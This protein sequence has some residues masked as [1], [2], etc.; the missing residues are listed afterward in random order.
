M[1]ILIDECLPRKLKHELPSHEVYTVPEIGWA[2]K[3]NGE[4]LRLMLGQFDVF[5]T[6]DNNMQ[7]Q[8]SLAGLEVAFIVLVAQNNK[9]LT[10]KP[11]MPKVLKVLETIKHGELITVRENSE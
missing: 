11:L 2:S 8:Q 5:I 4:L 1:K 7:H 6:I 9:L 3:K 10:L